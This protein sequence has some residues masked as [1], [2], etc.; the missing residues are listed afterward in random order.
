MSVE[1]HRQTAAD[2]HGGQSSALYAYASSGRVLAG[3]AGE[4]D[5][6][7]AA[8]ERGRL[9]AG[10]DSVE[11][12]ERLWALLDYV[13]PELAATK[14]REIGRE[15][16]ERA[17]AQWHHEVMGDGA[18]R[19]AT[20]TARRVLGVIDG[21]DLAVLDMLPGLDE[22]YVAT[23]LSADCGWSEPSADKRAAHGRW[24]AAQP[25]IADAYVTAFAITLWASVEEACHNE[26]AAV[27]P[28]HQRTAEDPTPH[29]RSR[30]RLRPIGEYPPIPP[31][32]ETVPAG[33]NRSGQDLEVVY[34]PGRYDVLV[35]HGERGGMFP[36]LAHEPSADLMLDTLA[37][38]GWEPHNFAGEPRVWIRDRAAA[39]RLA[40]DHREAGKQPEVQFNEL[41]PTRPFL[42]PEGSAALIP[43]GW[44]AE[45]AG[46]ASTMD[47]VLVEVVYN[48][49]R[50]DVM[51]VPHARTEAVLAV[52]ADQG[53]TQASASDATSHLLWRDRIAH[54]T[55]ERATPSP[56]AEVEGLGL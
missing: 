4:I 50:H 16:A 45:P 11:E 51:R 42:R 53:W 15:H 13:E 20:A 29:Q 40:T 14:A 44:I 39:E 5:D 30:P 28:D 47:S 23:R 22:R 56:A 18:K 19:D 8:V 55:L 36:R 6:C 1:R 7:L 54:A 52:L 43:P 37:I 26:V 24:D 31:G 10:L 32:W 35:V 9:D 38:T 3:I 21:G 49:Q 46:V 33:R 2:W 41:G 12:H 27:E 17:A 34:D 25:A 48:P